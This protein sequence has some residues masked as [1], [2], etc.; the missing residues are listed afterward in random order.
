MG[1]VGGSL[2][3]FA[4]RSGKSNK[5]KNR[6][7]ICLQYLKDF[8]FSLSCNTRSDSLRTCSCTGPS[9]SSLTASISLEMSSPCLGWI[10]NLTSFA[11]SV[12]ILLLK[13]R[14]YLPLWKSQVLKRGLRLYLLCQPLSI[15]ALLSVALQNKAPTKLILNCN[16]LGTYFIRG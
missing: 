3:P 15:F 2:V 12:D 10:P 8:S 7:I 16:V 6:I 13:Q 11:V 1:A 9:C 4:P 5:S 14:L